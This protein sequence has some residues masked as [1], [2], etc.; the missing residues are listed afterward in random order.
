[1]F[2]VREVLGWNTVIGLPC[3]VVPFVH[4]VWF[5]NAPDLND[6]GTH[7]TDNEVLGNQFGSDREAESLAEEAELLGAVAEIAWQSG[8]ALPIRRSRRGAEEPVPIATH[9]RRSPSAGYL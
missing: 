5:N 6:L 8:E 3:S 9:L 1:M 7:K 4:Y 2:I